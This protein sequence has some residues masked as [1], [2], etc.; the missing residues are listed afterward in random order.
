MPMVMAARFC[1]PRI[2]CHVVSSPF[3]FRAINRATLRSIGLSPVEFRSINGM[4]T[5]RFSKYEQEFYRDLIEQLDLDPERTLMVGDER[6]RDGRAR[7][8]GIDFY[9]YNRWGRLYDSGE[10]SELQGGATNLIRLLFDN[11]PVLSDE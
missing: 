3:F 1:T 5:G 9:H 7:D 2:P 10:R 4:E 11:G 8:V 6:T